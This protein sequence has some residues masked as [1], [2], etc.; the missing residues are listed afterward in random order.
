MSVISRLFFPLLKLVAFGFKKEKIK[1]VVIISA[2]LNVH[3]LRLKT[4][5]LQASSRWRIRQ[6]D[7]AGWELWTPARRERPG[8]MLEPLGTWPWGVGVAPSVLTDGLALL[9][10]GV[11]GASG[12]PYDVT[13]E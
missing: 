10:C 11:Q 5:V 9:G 3:N 7:W 13:L 12:M 1:S 2:S 6:C 8:G 4:V